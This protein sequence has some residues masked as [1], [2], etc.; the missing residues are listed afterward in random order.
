MRRQTPDLFSYS[1]GV[2]GRWRRVVIRQIEN[3]SG[4][5]KISRLYA[6]RQDDISAGRNPWDVTFEAMKLQLD[7]QGSLESIPRTGPLVVVAN[8]PFGLVD[9]VIICHLIAQVRP[10][11]R[12]L[13]NRVLEQMKDLRAYLLPIDF[14]DTSEARDINLNSRAA[15]KTH[16]RA[17]GAVIVFPAGGI[18]TAHRGLGPANDPPWGPFTAKLILS[19]KADVL[20]VYFHGQ[21]SRLFQIV[22]QFSHTLRL[23]LLAREVRRKMGGKVRVTIGKTIPHAELVTYPRREEMMQKLRE[24]TYA[25]KQI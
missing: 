15:A 13:I 12:I 22:S 14:T 7:L 6:D 19:S 1:N 23:A 16:L 2:D 3:V 20:P 4:L 5:R 18:S 11:F 8:H 24:E 17:G 9:G 10:D 25:L 21:N